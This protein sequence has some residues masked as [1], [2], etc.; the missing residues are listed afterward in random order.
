MG[1]DKSSSSAPAPEKKTVYQIL[2][3]AFPDK[4]AAPS[5]KAAP[6]KKA[7][8]A[9]AFSF[10]FGS[11]SAKAPAKKVIGKKAPVKKIVAKK[12][13]AKKITKIPKPTTVK[14]SKPVMIYERAGHI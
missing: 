8:S 12:T 6:T 7:A 9:P 4:D 3:A 14:K 1:K 2:K 11:D 10:S 5:K 13:T